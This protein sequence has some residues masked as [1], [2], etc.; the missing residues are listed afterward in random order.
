M[1]NREVGKR[2]ISI[3][4]L[5]IGIVL[6]VFIFTQGFK[7]YSTSRAFTEQRS[8][9]TISCL[10]Y[11]YTIKNLAYS[12]NTLSFDITHASYSDAENISSLTV[13]TDRTETLSFPPMLRGVSR[14]IVVEN[15]QVDSNFSLYPDRCSSYPVVCEMKEQRCR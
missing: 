14:H 12:N 3:F 13:I 15:V 9:P 2:A 8:E 7:T 6:A 5:T 10:G 1:V 4:L 11:A